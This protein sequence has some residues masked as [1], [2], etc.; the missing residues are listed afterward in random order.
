MYSNID[1]WEPCGSG[2]LQNL[3]RTLHSRQRRR[4]ITKFVTGATVAVAL[5]GV[6]GFGA[7]QMMPVEDLTCSEVVNLL[8]DYIHQ[9]LSMGMRRRVHKHLANCPSCSEH[10]RQMR[11]TGGE[12]RLDGLSDS[13]T[14]VH[15]NHD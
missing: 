5:I 13:I 12:T 8:D 4:F 11:D 10:H 7:V 6:V 1:D 15:N 14:L 2:E 3:T 9:R